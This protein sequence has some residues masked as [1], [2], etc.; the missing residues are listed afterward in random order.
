MEAYSSSMNIYNVY[1]NAVYNSRV[2]SKLAVFHCCHSLFFFRRRRVCF[3]PSV[4]G[5]SSSQYS[6]RILLLLFMC[7]LSKAT[8][9]TLF[10]WQVQSKAQINILTFFSFVIYNLFVYASSS[11]LFGVASLAFLLLP[12]LPL[13]LMMC[14]F[15]AHRISIVCSSID[16]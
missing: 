10:K 8:F 9:R 1:A 3:H 12:P 5:S 15:D 13:L 2:N 16:K 14:F 11:S 7:R 6:V 4:T